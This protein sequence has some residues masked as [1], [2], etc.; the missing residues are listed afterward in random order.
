MPNPSEAE[1][2]VI[3]YSLLVNGLIFRSWVTSVHERDI[4]KICHL[5]Y[6]EGISQVEIGAMMGLSRW[7]VGRAIKDARERELIS[8]SINHPQSDLTESEIALAKR[9][10]LKEAIVVDINEFDRVSPLDQLGTAGARY[11]T[12][13]IE[14]H[15]ILGVTWGST[16]SYVAKNLSKVEAKHLK[17]V[18][19]GGGLGTIEGTDNPALTAML[20]QKLGAEAHVIQAPIIVQNK[21]IRDTLVKETRIRETIAIARKSDLVIFGVGLIGP[22][23]LLWQ[24]GLLSPRDASRLKRAGAVG[25]ICGRFYNDQGVRCS[26]DLEDRTIGLNLNELKKIKHKILIV[27]GLEKVRAILGALRGNLVDTLI[28]DIDTA[29]HLLKN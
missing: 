27:A 29:D 17:L 6:K 25:A 22:E 23:S 13:I 10:D 5:F 26:H 8:I 9:Y 18:Q 16:V 19:I 20:G 11:L 7:K 1:L 3:C 12:S 28:L 15:R 24:S 4:I 21:S 2:G 14:H